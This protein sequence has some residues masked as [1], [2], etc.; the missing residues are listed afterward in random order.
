[1]LHYTALCHTM[2]CDAS[3]YDTILYYAIRRMLVE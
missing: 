3:L 1:M 2:V